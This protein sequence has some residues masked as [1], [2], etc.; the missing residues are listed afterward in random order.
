MKNDPT[1]KTTKKANSRKWKAQWKKIVSTLA[2][3]TVFCTTYALIL[4]AIT[5]NSNTYCGL[6]EHE[7]TE[8]CYTKE[9]ICGFEEG[10]AQGES[11]ETA[12]ET[13]SETVTEIVTETVIEKEIQQEN[14]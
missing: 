13:V 14:H 9:L 8:A 12:P 4:P 1:R 3:V 5:V 7:H 2:A 6:E 11:G 10:E